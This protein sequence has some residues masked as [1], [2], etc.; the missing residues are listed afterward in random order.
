MIR[1]ARSRSLRIIH[2]I[3]HRRSGTASALSAGGNGHIMSP[4]VVAS[5]SSFLMTFPRQGAAAVVYRFRGSFD[6]G[7]LQHTVAALS[8]AHLPPSSLGAH[9]WGL[10]RAFVITPGG[11]LPIRKFVPDLPLCHFMPDFRLVLPASS[12]SPAAVELC[13][14]LPAAARTGASVMPLRLCQFGEHVPAPFPGPPAQSFLRSCIFFPP[15]IVLDGAPVF[16]SLKCPF[17]ESLPSLCTS[18]FH[19]R[20]LR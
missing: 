16:P 7:I 11:S 3:F 6:I 4:S 15:T 17:H 8:H 14:A 19:S 9:P 5:C 20:P 13:P 1:C 10:I 12:V 2:L 18:P